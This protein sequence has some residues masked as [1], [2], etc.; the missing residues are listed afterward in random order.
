MTHRLPRAP[1]PHVAPPRAQIGQLAG[2]VA[3]LG[4]SIAERY[5]R[6]PDRLTKAAGAGAA[7]ESVIKAHK[8]SPSPSTSAA[9]ASSKP[10]PMADDEYAALKQRM[11][12]FM[13]EEVYPNEE[14]F[15]RQCHAYH[16]LTEWTHPPVLIELMAK[17]KE[18]GL[19]NLW[20]PADSAA[21]VE[22][23]CMAWLMSGMGA[24]R[25]GL[26]SGMGAH[27]SGLMRSTHA[28]SW[29]ARRTWRTAA[30]G[31]PRGLT[32]AHALMHTHRFGA[33]LT[34]LQYA[35]LCEIQGT[36]IH[37]E[38]AAQVSDRANRPSQRIARR[39]NRGQAEEP[40]AAEP[41]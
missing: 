31:T 13:H 4:A 38:M 28:G 33:G 37:G 30:L 5:E 9:T 15:A 8:P 34:N 39:L 29:A 40:V 35:D 10:A 18:R 24:D 16:G 20:L 1:P 6:A 25:R 21:L 11:V 26:M 22:G 32:H 23:R 12:D 19:W 7:F 27:R 14:E 41:T 3:Q 36:S 2:A 17:A